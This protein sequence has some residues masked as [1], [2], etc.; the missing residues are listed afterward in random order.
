MSDSR[1]TGQS[2]RPAIRLLAVPLAAVAAIASAAE[3]TL[4]TVTT[5]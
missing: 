1:K 2:A 5:L 4:P 3:T